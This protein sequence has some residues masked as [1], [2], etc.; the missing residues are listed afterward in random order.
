[1]YHVCVCTGDGSILPQPLVS[2][3]APASS[4]TSANSESAERPTLSVMAFASTPMLMERLKECIRHADVIHKGLR[5]F[6]QAKRHLFPRFYFLADDEMLQVTLLHVHSCML[7][8]SILILQLFSQGSDPLQVQPHLIRCF[9]GITA[10]H[11]EYSS[12]VKSRSRS[13]RAKSSTGSAL[14]ARLSGPGEADVKEKRREGWKQS[15]QQ[16]FD[17]TRAKSPHPPGDDTI[18]NIRKLSAMGSERVQSLTKT[19][20]SLMLAASLK[21]SKE[22][23]SAR[24]E[25]LSVVS[26]SGECVPLVTR[27]I[28]ELV[29][30]ALEKWMAQLE[31][32]MQST[33][34]I[35]ALDC[36]ADDRRRD[37]VDWVKV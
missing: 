7:E 9:D 22:E 33:V 4:P 20:M 37:L 5:K 24:L 23:P 28:P 27:V 2:N 34:R 3:S 18:S 1:M 30:N 19:A 11:F 21:K 6:L 16:S 14:W 10:L 36:V 35:L 31:A 29:G 25:V 15:L 8:V 17:G 13:R 26:G 12:G 32:S